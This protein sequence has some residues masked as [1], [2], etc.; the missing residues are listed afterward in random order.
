VITKIPATTQDD[1]RFWHGD[2]FF[3]NMFY[4][5]T[6]RRILAIDPRGQMAAGQYCLF[7]DL[8]YDLAKLAHSVIG[9]YDKII[10]GRASLLENGPRDWD[11]TLS[12]QPHQSLIEAIFMKEVQARYE[13]D[14][15]VLIAMTALLFF[16]M[17]PL[18][19][20]RPDLQKQMLANGLRLATLP[21]GSL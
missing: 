8:R 13:L 2:M 9:Q 11:L 19:T 5:F 17:L 10:L 3:G 1:I 7:G 21:K 14:P 16:S 4:D 20:D 15:E 18:H 12:A 6:A